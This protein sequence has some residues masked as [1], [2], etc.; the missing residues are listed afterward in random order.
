MAILN[1]TATIGPEP[2]YL[3]LG[4]VTD[5]PRTDVAAFVRWEPLNPDTEKAG[6]AECRRAPMQ[7]HPALRLAVAAEQDLS[8]EESGW[9]RKLPPAEHRVSRNS[10]RHRV[11]QEGNL[12]S[13]FVSEPDLFGHAHRIGA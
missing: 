6:P 12:R 1:A 9:G 2:V 3:P 11:S 10:A 7:S 8:A 4:G 5:V 13:E